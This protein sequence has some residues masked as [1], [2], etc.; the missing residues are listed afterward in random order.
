MV[1]CGCTEGVVVRTAGW[2]GGTYNQYIQRWEEGQGSRVKGQDLELRI[3]TP[4]LRK[5]VPYVGLRL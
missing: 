3:Y 1:W 4:E 5:T 2:L